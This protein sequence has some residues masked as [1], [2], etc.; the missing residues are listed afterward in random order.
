MATFEFLTKTDVSE[1]DVRQV[2]STL[3]WGILWKISKERT[4]EGWKLKVYYAKLTNEVGRTWVGKWD[5]QRI[6]L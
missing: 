4:E 6:D 2:F 3:G 1:W 5:V